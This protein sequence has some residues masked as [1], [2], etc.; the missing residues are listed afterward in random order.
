M[1]RIGLCCLLAIMAIA[2]LPASAAEQTSALTQSISDFNRNTALGAVLEL[3]PGTTAELDELRVL[4]DRG[5]KAAQQA[6]AADPKSADAQYA[7]GSWL[8]YGYQ[9]VES[10]ETSFDAAGNAT[11]QPITRVVQ[12]LTDDPEEGLGA[13][14]S[15][16]E[17][18]PANG[19]YLLDYGAALLDY[20]EPDRAEAV[21]KGIW[22]GRPELSVQYKMRAAL[23]LSTIAE[24]NGDLDGAREWI[25]SALA[26]DPE[27]APAVDRLRQLDA[28]VLAAAIAA[29]TA[30]PAEEE[31]TQ[32]VEPEPEA[33]EQEEAP[34]EE[35][36]Y[37]GE[38]QGGGQTS[39]QSAEG[40]YEEPPAT[41]Y[42]EPPAS[43]YQEP[44][45]TS[46][47]GEPGGYEE[48]PSSSYQEP[49]DSGY[50]EPPSESYPEAPQQSY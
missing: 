3:R 31:E 19:E 27:T 18:A 1:K 47:Q 35:G 43:A 36:G 22:A 2:I 30:P 45:S 44:P 4:A 15:A 48:P 42:E 40:T 16:T 49:P 23:L 26:L 34:S 6:A 25:Y 5:L 38:T 13:L 46:Y 41:S 9:A 50:Q 14:K 20:D 7:L 17:L 11:T 8:L 21:L 32:T 10:E 29:A 28:E 24:G 37:P 12:G 39:D 33:P